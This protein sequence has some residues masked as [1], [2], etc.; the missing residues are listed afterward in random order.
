MG[1]RHFVVFDCIAT[2]ASNNGSEFVDF[3][4]GDSFPVDSNGNGGIGVG[5]ARV[6]GLFTVHLPSVILKKSFLNG[7][8][9]PSSLRFQSFNHELHCCSAFRAKSRTCIR[10][11]S[12]SWDLWSF[13]LPTLSHQMGQN[14]CDAFF[15]RSLSN[16]GGV[17]DW[18]A[19]AV[20]TSSATGDVP[21]ERMPVSGS[22]SR[23]HRAQ[24]SGPETLDIAPHDAAASS[25]KQTDSAVCKLLTRS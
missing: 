16:G 5:S 10:D 13:A 20:Q 4:L 11:S 1:V 21:L 7:F 24:V 2:M 19:L 18:S 3:L 14:S 6:P 15:P 8:F 12:C 9:V 23:Q 17:A 22:T 25:R